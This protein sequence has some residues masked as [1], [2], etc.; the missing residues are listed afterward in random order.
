ME[1]ANPPGSPSGR[2]IKPLRRGTKR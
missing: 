1:S 2:K